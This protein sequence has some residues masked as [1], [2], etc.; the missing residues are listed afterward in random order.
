MVALYAMLLVAEAIPTGN[1]AA[2]RIRGLA[3]WTSAQLTRHDF[4]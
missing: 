3:R 1:G 4:L 2:A